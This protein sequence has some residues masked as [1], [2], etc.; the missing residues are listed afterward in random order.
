MWASTRVRLHDAAG[1]YSEQQK[2]LSDLMLHL[3][4][5]EA[6]SV[7]RFDVSFMDGPDFLGP[8]AGK[9]TA[10]ELVRFERLVGCDPARLSRESVG[11]KMKNKIGDYDALRDHYMSG[12][13]AF[14][15]LDTRDYLHVSRRPEYRRELGLIVQ[16][17]TEFLAENF[18]GND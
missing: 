7:F 13:D 12:R 11:G 16:A 18:P 5:R 1:M 9:R 6:S 3:R 14:I 8:Y 15:T 10:D 17:P 4:V 2:A